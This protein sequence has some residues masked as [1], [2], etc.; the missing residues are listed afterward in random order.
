MLSMAYDFENNWILILGNPIEKRSVLIFVICCALTVLAA[1]GLCY[2]FMV[3]GAADEVVPL[4]VV[5]A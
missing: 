1:V 5:E 4:E 3:Y 2:C